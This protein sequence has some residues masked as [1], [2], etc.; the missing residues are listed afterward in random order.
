MPRQ[1]NEADP[2]RLSGSPEGSTGA[3]AG[4]AARHPSF[5]VSSIRDEAAAWR[6]SWRRTVRP[7]RRSGR[8]ST[9]IVGVAVMVALASAEYTV[10]NGDTL[11]RI[12]ARHDTTVAAIV[13]AN[14]ISNPNRIRI[15]QKLI[16]P[17]ADPAVGTPA[18]AA[19]YQVVSG[20]TL[21]KIAARHQTTV[22]AL[23]AANELTN[24]NKLKI[25]QSLLLPVAQSGPAPAPVAAPPPGP[26]ATHLVAPGDTLGSIAAK[27]ATTVEAIKAA[28]GLTNS[29]IYVG[30]TLTIGAP[31]PP[32]V[33]SVSAPASYT[34]AA[35][36]TLGSIAARLGVTASSLAAGNAITNPNLIV[37]GQ[38]LTV[39]GVASWRCPVTGGTYFNDWGFPRS[40]GRLHQGND[41]FAPRGTPIVAPVA[42]TVE[43]KTGA[44]GGL[45]FWLAGSDGVR[46]IGTHLE[47]FG[48]AGQVSAGDVIGYVGDSGNAV[49]SRPHVHFEMAKDGQTFNPYPTL[50]ANGC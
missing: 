44:I 17:G 2:V 30:T 46:Y 33:T 21:A 42:G 36:D 38:V 49:G 14:G 9:L 22:A 25:G 3:L 47:G 20:D 5:L 43:F 29:L 24:P 16:I 7:H 11:G 23:V 41:I 28:N 12:A 4:S 40:G 27:F 1:L 15:G 35:G 32:P 31:A 34:V 18:P 8:R 45:Q 6:A 13:E 37:V 10:E 39:P 48:I 19:T 26:V 50:Q